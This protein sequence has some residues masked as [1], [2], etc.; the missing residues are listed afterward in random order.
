MC[1]CFSVLILIYTFYIACFLVCLC[2]GNVTRVARQVK[3]KIFKRE[4]SSLLQDRNKSVGNFDIAFNI[5]VG[6]LIMTALVAL[7]QEGIG[8]ERQEGKEEK[9]RNVK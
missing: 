3:T 4:T 1:V 8:Q 9:G 6:H 5:I 2:F 7:A